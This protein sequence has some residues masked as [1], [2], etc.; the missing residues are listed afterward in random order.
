MVIERIKFIYDEPAMIANAD[1]KDYLVIGD[2]H[3]GMELGLS[4]KGVHLFGASEHMSNRIKQIMKE[5]SLEH[6]IILG[7]VKESILYPEAPE[8]RL[9]RQFFRE[10]DGF[11]INIVGGNHDAHLADIIGR[12]VDKE[13][14]I[15][16]LGLIHGNR[17]PSSEF[18]LLDY[19]VS[20]HEHVAVRIRDSNG[21]LYEQK[22]WAIY[23]VNRSA[24]KSDYPAFNPDIRLIS[25]PAFNEL[26]MGTVIEKGKSGIS[27]AIASNLFGR[28]GRELYNL[29][30]QR[31][32]I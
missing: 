9:L 11:K 12:R 23:K 10:L 4:K 5:F 7:D 19:I 27:P 32:E 22:A 30:G 13:L 1:G 18:M 28:R 2:L 3:I 16:D 26:I 17:K 15:G 20:A 24:A 25:I 21:V 6:M 31:I 29:L 14:I 8:I